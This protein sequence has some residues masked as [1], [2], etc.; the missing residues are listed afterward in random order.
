MLLPLLL[1]ES[2]SIILNI[3]SGLALT[4][5]ASSAIY[6]ATKAALNTFSISLRYQLETT[7][8]K[9]F[10]AF[11][12]LVDTI[13]TKGRGKGKISSEYAAAKL[14]KGIEKEIISNDIGKIKILRF[15]LRFW[16]KLAYKILKKS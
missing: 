5:K 7:N 10:Q 3:N 13:M 14:I 1:K 4:P 9:V 12:P 16:P 15:L 8:V 6:C 11:L 2:T